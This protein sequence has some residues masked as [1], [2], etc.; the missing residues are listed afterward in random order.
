MREIK[1]VAVLGS[2]VMGAA[3]AAHLANCG[4]PSVMLDIVPPNLSDSDKKK[5]AKRNAIVD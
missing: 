2:G 1:R 5:K 4:I 3:I